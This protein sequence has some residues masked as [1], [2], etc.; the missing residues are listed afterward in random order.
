MPSIQNAYNWAIECCANPNVG[1]SQDYRNQQTVNGITYYDCSSFIWF[2]LIAGGFDVISAN[3]G[4]TWPFT[5]STMTAALRVL[6]FT[7]YDP[8][9]EWL[10]G[11]ILLRTGHTEMAFDRTRTMG[12]HT[13]NTELE[14]QV[15]I[16]ANDSRGNWLQLWRW[17]TGATNEWI[18]GNRWLTIGEMQNNASI[19]YY[20]LLR[21]GFSVN[22]ISGI[23]GNAG[24]PHTLGESS[25]NPGIWQNLTPNPSLGFGLFQWT[26][27]TNYTDWAA[28]NGYQNDDGYGQL[29]WLV[30]QTTVT[31]QWIP[32]DEYPESWKEFCESTKSPEYLAYA[33]LN[34]WE[35]AANRNQ[36]ERQQNARYWYEWYNNSYVPPTNPPMDGGEWKSSM[37]IWMMMRRRLRR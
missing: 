20:T 5:T 18:K 32:T 35:R 24:G 11:D 3:G 7:Q 2:S 8:D 22:T 36:P 10:P 4:S 30:T 1:Y 16:N 15:S 17:E 12:A 6:G 13:A 25:V 23:L 27:S 9:I 26:P 37:P 14:Q 31:G 19:I 29:E 33:F 34:N 28:E 21:E